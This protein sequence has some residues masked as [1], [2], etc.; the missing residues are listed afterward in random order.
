MIHGPCGLARFNSPCMKEGRCSKF[1]PK[2]FTCATVD[3]D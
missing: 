2:K 3:E 1:Y